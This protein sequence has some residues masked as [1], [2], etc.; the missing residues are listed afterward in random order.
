MPFF[1]IFFFAASMIFRA[2]LG[3][4]CF[5]M[6][7][8]WTAVNKPNLV[9]LWTPTI[10]APVCLAKEIAVPIPLLECLEP[11]RQSIIFLTCIPH[12]AKLS[13]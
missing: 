12:L 4:F 2:S 1:S 5:G 3:Y 13:I 7:G 6:L 11:S 8:R 10:V 9:T